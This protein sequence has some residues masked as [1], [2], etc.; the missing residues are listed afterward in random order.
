MYSVDNKTGN[1]NIII[2]F[3]VKLSI[4]PDISMRL[5]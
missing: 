1:A 5:R 2:T 3:P 4:F